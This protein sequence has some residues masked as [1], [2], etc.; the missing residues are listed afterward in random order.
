MQSNFLDHFRD[1]ASKYSRTETALSQCPYCSMQCSMQVHKEHSYY[2]SRHVITPHKAD[3][4]NQGRMCVKGM[5]SHTPA[6]DKG[7]LQTPLLRRNGKH[8]P[9]SW[10][11]AMDWFGRKIKMLQRQYGKDAVSVYGGGSLTNEESYLLGKFAR[12]A[13]QTRHID[14]NGRFCMSSAASA[15]NQVFGIDRGM[16]NPL[17]DLL[18][19]KCV[20]LAGTNIAD[21]QPTMMAYLRKAKANGAVI[22]AIDPRVTGTTKI[23]DLHLQLKPGTDAILA[24]GLL[25]VIVDEGFVNE[26]FVQQHTTG[27]EELLEHLRSI[28][29]QQVAAITGVPVDMIGLAARA[30]GKAESGMLFT[31]RGVEQHATGVKNVCSYLNMV[32]LTGKIGSPGNGYGAVT[33]QANGQGGRE[34]GQKADQ[35]PGYRLIENPEHRRHIA[36]VWGI[37]ESKLPRKGIPAYELFPAIMR[38]DIRSMIVLSSNPVVSNPNA[39]LV[40]EA[41]KRLDALIVIDLYY[42]ETAKLADLILPGSSHLEDEGTMTTLEGRVTLRRAV[43]P[44]PGKARLDWQI[45]CDMA[46]ALGKRKGFSYASAEEIFEELRIASKGGIADYSG[47]T[48]ARMEQENGVFWPCKREE[49]AGVVRLFED[50]RFYHADGK[51]RLIAVSR[52]LP[53]EPTDDKFPIILTTGRVM[54]HYLSGVQTRRT[55][56]LREKVPEPFVQIHPD[57]ARKCGLQ[58]GERARLVS[59]RGEIQL[60]VRFSADIR[61]DT[62]FVPFHWGDEQCINRLTLPTMDPQSGMPSFKA[63]AVRVEPIHATIQG[64]EQMEDEK[65]KVVAYR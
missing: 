9:V 8:V 13:L 19:T 33:G 25:K 62:V 64:E 4:V 3:P 53:A 38:G 40:E 20:I 44:L 37:K 7:R 17:S 45:L 10:K 29:L 24:S 11:T 1:L 5:E 16:T 15:S 47:I 39:H 57:T 12:V 58:E 50:G 22:I 34:H 60:A 36:Q 21:C 56:A 43:S 59:R 23:A 14:Y 51:A 6:L 32:L 31:A 26:T 55:P 27:A 28:D 35:L 42:S 52:T 18:L 49:E 54:Q 63:C 41:L 30:Y 46:V 2:S 48:Y 61:T 65:E